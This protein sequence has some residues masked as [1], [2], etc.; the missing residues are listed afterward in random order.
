MPPGYAGCQWGYRDHVTA[1]AAVQTVAGSLSFS[2]VTS[3]C[4]T[5]Y[6]VR[7]SAVF[8]NVNKLTLYP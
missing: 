2:G 6:I 7:V 8:F 3:F 4:A 1:P 5:L